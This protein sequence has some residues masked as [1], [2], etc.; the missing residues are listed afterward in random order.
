MVQCAR[1]WWWATSGQLFLT[2]RRI[3]FAPDPLSV[4][5]RK[6]VVIHRHDISRWS[7]ARRLNLMVPF[8]GL[9]R[10]AVVV[11]TASHRSYAFWPLPPADAGDAISNWL[12][13]NA[14]RPA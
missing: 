9:F 14:P 1:R 4:I 10:S 6:P 3:L 7:R 8:H 5:E 2:D 13:K 11:L 12:S